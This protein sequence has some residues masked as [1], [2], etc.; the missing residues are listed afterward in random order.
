MTNV[1]PMLNSLAEVSA[2]EISKQENPQGYS[3]SATVARK[4]AKV[5]KVARDQL[6]S[7]LGRSVISPAKA[8][9]Y[10]PE[11]PKRIEDVEPSEDD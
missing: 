1:E 6:E 11:P 3:Q 10:L 2:A 9:D 8:S 4:G 7:Q 5:A